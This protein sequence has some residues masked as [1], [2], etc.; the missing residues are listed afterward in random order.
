MKRTL[1]VL[2]VLALAL[3]VAFISCA[4]SKKAGMGGEIKGESFQT[5]GWIDEDTFRITETGSPGERFK[6]K[7]TVIQKKAAKEVALISAQCR[8][9]EKF[10][11]VK[12]EGAAGM[13]D[14]EL[15][16][17]A[18]A[19]EFAGTITGGS[20]IKTTYDD[21]N[22]CEIVYEVKAKG[23]KRKVSASSIK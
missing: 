4:S 6:A 3:P 9:V 12:I 7:D 1:M 8:I 22:N 17:S 16:G 10:T 15:S 21:D 19:K 18:A 23:L 14:F 5:E 11:G 13:K 20:I 2:M